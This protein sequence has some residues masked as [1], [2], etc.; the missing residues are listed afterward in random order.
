MWPLLHTRE[1][2]YIVKCIPIDVTRRS[3]EECYLKLPITR[4]NKSMFLS[5]KTHILL[6]SGTSVD[7]NPLVLIMY[8]IR[9]V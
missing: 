7:C 6:N 5:P 9:G 8:Q 4:N 1:V 3:I 2:A